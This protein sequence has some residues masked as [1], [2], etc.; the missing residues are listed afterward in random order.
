MFAAAVA[1][2]DGVPPLGE[3]KGRGYAVSTTL[4]LDLINHDED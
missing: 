2:T 3:K 4:Y 1:I